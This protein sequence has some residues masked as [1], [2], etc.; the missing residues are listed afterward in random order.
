MARRIKIIS[1]TSMTNMRKTTTDITHKNFLQLSLSAMASLPASLSE[2]DTGIARENEDGGGS[3]EVIVSSTTSSEV[4][5]MACG[6]TQCSDDVDAGGSASSC[7]DG[8]ASS[9][10]SSSEG[11]FCP[12]GVA[13]LA[14]SDSPGKIAA[15]EAAAAVLLELRDALKNGEIVEKGGSGAS[16]VV[17]YKEGGEWKEKTCV[18]LPLEMCGVDQCGNA[19][20]HSRLIMHMTCRLDKDHCECRLF[21][22][23]EQAT[24][25]G[26]FPGHYLFAPKRFMNV[27]IA[28]DIYKMCSIH[29]R[30]VC[31]EWQVGFYIP[32]L[33]FVIFAHVNFEG[34][35]E[36]FQKAFHALTTK[37]A[38]S[39]AHVLSFY[40][41]EQPD[42]FNKVNLYM[43][44]D[45]H[46]FVQKIRAFFVK[47]IP[48]LMK[49]VKFVEQR[50]Y[51]KPKICHDEYAGG[52]VY[53]CVEEARKKD[54]REY[55]NGEIIL[56]KCST[57]AATEL[58]YIEPPSKGPFFDGGKMETE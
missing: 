56:A 52:F 57:P 39:G 50:L 41:A 48:A 22:N 45:T 26:R 1:T 21:L 51:W 8:P 53:L 54:F 17:M 9:S 15:N 29:P 5:K 11:E 32:T 40:K 25:G 14:K 34:S 37:L 23:Y 18:K 36:L 30:Q 43:N 12:E 38:L 55:P 49:S 35:V 33:G 19:F 44:L 3:K 31:H 58:L 20:L 47:E 42:E 27:G 28:E 24:E 4:K 46:D 7:S 16:G 13:I 10:S 2:T 6:G